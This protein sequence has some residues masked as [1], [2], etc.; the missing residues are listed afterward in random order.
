MKLFTACKLHNYHQNL[1]TFKRARTK[2][3]LRI[4]LLPLTESKSD[5]QSI[6]DYNKTYQSQ[7]QLRY[8]I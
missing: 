7:I 1:K 2:I 4:P 5:A 3:H 6:H 8:Q